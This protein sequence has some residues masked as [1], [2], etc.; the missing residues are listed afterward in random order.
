LKGVE[1]PEPVML[2]RQPTEK[3]LCSSLQVIESKALAETIHFAQ[4]DTELIFP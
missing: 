3:H 2:I 4:D 1:K